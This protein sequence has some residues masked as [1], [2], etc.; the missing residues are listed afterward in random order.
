MSSLL[1]AARDSSHCHICIRQP[2]KEQQNTIS[3]CLHVSQK[4]SVGPPRKCRLKPEIRPFRVRYSTSLLSFELF[5]SAGRGQPRLSLV[6]A[7]STEALAFVVIAAGSSSNCLSR[8][9]I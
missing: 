2:Q 9:L 7:H 5:E 6:E 1:D 3:T 4:F 8:A